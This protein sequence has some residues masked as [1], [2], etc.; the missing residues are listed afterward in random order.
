M[1]TGH[2]DVHLDEV[3][4]QGINPRILLL[5]LKWKEPAGVAGKMITTHPVHYEKRDSPVYDEIEIVNCD[6]R[7]KVEI[8]T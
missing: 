7:L 6:L 5:E 4:P 8:V 2:S 1:T 3:H